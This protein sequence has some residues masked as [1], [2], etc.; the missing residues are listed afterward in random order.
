MAKAI[1]VSAGFALACGCADS[2]APKPGGGG[3]APTP[4]TGTGGAAASGATGA[5]SGSAT[6]TVTDQLTD[7]DKKRAAAQGTCPVSD[8]SIGDH[9]KVIKVVI[10][11]KS[12]F[13]CCDECVPKLKAEPD[14]YLAKLKPAT[15]EKEAAG[16][17]EKSGS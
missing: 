4:A 8:E 17:T 2:A 13:V 11:D 16:A 14:K 15:V 3:P 9:G 6:T 5:D 10:K 12:V 1:V 7:E